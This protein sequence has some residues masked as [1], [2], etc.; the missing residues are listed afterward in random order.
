MFFFSIKSFQLVEDNLEFVENV[1]ES[2]ET[3]V[4]DHTALSIVKIASIT[5]KRCNDLNKKLME[6]FANVMNRKEIIDGKPPENKFEDPLFAIEEITI[7]ADIYKNYLNAD[8]QT[9]N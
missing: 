5:S 7:N 6:L 1:W 8:F 2:F 3:E 9:I 4:R